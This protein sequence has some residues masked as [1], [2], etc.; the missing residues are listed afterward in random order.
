MARDRPEAPATTPVDG[1]AEMR[2]LTWEG[3]DLTIPT[4]AARVVT[5]GDGVLAPVLDLA[6]PVVATSGIAAVTVPPQ[7]QDVVRALPTLGRGRDGDEITAADVVEHGPDL[8]LAVEGT[9]PALVAE[10]S[11]AVPV[12]VVPDE[13]PWQ[14]RV[15]RL[16]D[17]LGR[18]VGELPEVL[19]AH[20][21]AIAA[22]YADTWA[23]A[24]VVVLRAWDTERITAYGP[25]SPIGRLYTAAGARFVEP[26]D[27]RDHVDERLENV[28]S[29]LAD[30]DL[31]MMASDYAGGLDAFTGGSLA[32][33]DPVTW[34]PALVRGA[35]VLGI[36][37]Y[38]Q[39]H[40]LLDRLAQAAG[41]LAAG[42]TR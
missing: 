3:Q 6:A 2:R 28:L 9:D 18:P 11:A 27:G 1:N 4:R 26:V 30:A 36:T 19:D 29:V 16:A 13:L 8:V 5:L 40:D 25:L 22:E 20:A 14:E 32:N 39:A 34:H 35:G 23:R 15:A 7:R 10:V 24:R 17:V 12:V 31:A 41:D 21:R 37:S 38:A 33:S 42:A